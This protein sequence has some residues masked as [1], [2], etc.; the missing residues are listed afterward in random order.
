MKLRKTP[1]AG[2]AL[3]VLALANPAFAAGNL[4]LETPVTYDPNAGVVQSVREQCQ[5]ERMLER[6]V[7]NVLA[8]RNGSGQGTLAA[9]ADAQGGPL[10]RLR[11]THVLGVGGGAWS[12][13]KSLTVDAELVE[14][15]QVQRRT[16]ITRSTTGGAFGGFKGTCSLIERCAVAIAKDVGAW[17]ADPAARGTEAPAAEPADKPASSAN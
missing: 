2:L 14:K 12:G 9:G 8:G 7:G 10:V 15:G 13:P 3:I 11:I 1:R 17:A 5:V 6:E 16:K 4:L